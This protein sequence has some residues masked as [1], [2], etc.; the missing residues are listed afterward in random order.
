MLLLLLRS[1]ART[2]TVYSKLPE[3][4]ADRWVLLL[5]PM[6]ATGGSVIKAIEVLV[7]HSKFTISAQLSK[8][9][10]IDHIILTL[11][12]SLLATRRPSGTHHLRQPRR[13]ARGPRKRLQALPYGTPHLRLG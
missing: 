5:D 11:L 9:R 7:D 13:L 8:P 2:H 10:S 12:S 4:I 6:L 3:D 1:L